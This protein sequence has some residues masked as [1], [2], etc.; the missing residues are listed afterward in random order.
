MNKNR[1]VAKVLGG[2]LLML[3]LS[4]GC[5]PLKTYERA[6]LMTRVMEE[7]TG[8]AEDGFEVHIHRTREGMSGA[9]IGAGASC[10]CN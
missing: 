5:A 2:V 6:A 8:S 7:T 10:G 4:S 1:R 3:P 9:E